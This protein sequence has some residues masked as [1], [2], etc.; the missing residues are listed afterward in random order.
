LRAWAVDIGV[1]CV[2]VSDGLQ[3]LT[4]E[5]KARLIRQLSQDFTVLAETGAKSS[6]APVVPSKW[7]AELE[8]DLESGASWVV[9]EGRESGTVGLYDGAGMPREALIDAIARRLPLD[10]VIFESPQRAQQAWLISRLGADINLGNIDPNEVLPL[11]TLRLG[12]RA[13]TALRRPRI[14]RFGGAVCS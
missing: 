4:P 5:R 9:T 1:D 7:I 2:E 12:L 13:D 11:E 14:A 10:R 6:D 3:T 8:S